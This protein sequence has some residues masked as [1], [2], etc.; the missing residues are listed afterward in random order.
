MDYASHQFVSIWQCC[1]EFQKTMLSSLCHDKWTGKKAV[2]FDV[3]ALGQ[4]HDF[5]ANNLDLLSL[6]LIITSF[7]TRMIGSLELLVS[8]L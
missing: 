6:I 2:M 8:F 5:V 4:G 1:M 3:L 7:C